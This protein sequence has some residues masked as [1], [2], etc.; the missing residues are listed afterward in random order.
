MAL[1]DD[2]LKVGISN[3]LRR[4]SYLGDYDD[5]LET[6]ESTRAACFTL[7]RYILKQTGYAA[8]PEKDLPQKLQEW[9]GRTELREPSVINIEYLFEL[10]DQSMI[11]VEED[12][13]KDFWKANITDKNEK[14]ALLA[15]ST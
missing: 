4:R 9:D 1:K 12:G 2:Y 8:I 7:E 6:W 10:I 15:G 5:Y 14:P 3:Q 11:E 13:W